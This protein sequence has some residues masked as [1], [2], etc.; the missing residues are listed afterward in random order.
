MEPEIIAAIVGGF[1]A[2]IAGLIPLVLLKSREKKA[3]AGK[4]FPP[5]EG[6]SAAVGIVQRGN[7]VVMVQRRTRYRGLSWQFPAGVIKPGMD[8]RDKVESEVANETGLR[9]KFKRYLGARVHEETKVLCHY[10]QCTYLDGELKNLDPEE[11]SQVAWVKAGEVRNYV[12]SSLFIE[13][14]NL[15]DEIKDTAGICV[16]LGVILFEG[17][18]LLVEK[19]GNGGESRWQLPGGTIEAK[20]TEKKALIREVLEETGVA[21]SPK[22]KLGERIHPE[23]NQQISYWY[24][25]YKSGEAAVREPDKF[26]G[27]Q[28][29]AALDTVALLGDS[30]FEPVKA[31]LENH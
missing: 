25:E 3:A 21:C 5:G 18:A 22:K 29:I 11:N 12:T 24:C 27:V 23:T 7:E 20:E 31:I 10:F 8:P 28:W 19:K 2:I 9:C 16:V 26:S 6:L 13:V 14:E 4:Q 1:F 30:L 17:K 15:L